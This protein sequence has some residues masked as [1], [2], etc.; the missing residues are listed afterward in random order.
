[1]T[2]FVYGR[3]E[4]IAALVAKLVS[5]QEP[6]YGRCKTIGVTDDK[7]NFL[8]GVV[9]YHYDPAS[10]S[11]EMTGAALDSSW[12]S[13]KTLN[14]IGDYV[15]DECGCQLL[16]VDVR[17]DNE[18][19]L[20]ILAGVGFSFTRVARLG[21]RNLD[22]VICTLTDDDWYAGKISHGRPKLEE[23]A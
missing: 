1:M 20:R 22:G 6:N 7:G 9:L 8:G 3:D 13:R 11:I 18:R 16:R 23:A 4:E 5:G 2:C 21:G 15:F 14:R 12:L 10:G 19:V 17:E